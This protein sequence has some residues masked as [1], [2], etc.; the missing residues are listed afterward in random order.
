MPSKLQM[1]WTKI[2][3]YFYAATETG[4]DIMQALIDAETVC[5]L[6]ALDDLMTPQ[7]TARCQMS[8]RMTRKWQILAVYVDD[9]ILAAGEDRTGTLLQRAGREV[10]HISH[11][12]FLSPACSSHLRR[13][14]KD[15]ISANKLKAGNAQ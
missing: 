10:L 9:Y 7:T 5:P 15:P 1:G 12:L 4:R 3:G 8:L 13:R 14:G 2:V 6:H 11:G